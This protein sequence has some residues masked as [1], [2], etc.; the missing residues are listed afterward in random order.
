MKKTEFVCHLYVVVR[1]TENIVTGQ[2]C[3]SNLSVFDN[4]PDAFE[5]ANNLEHFAHEGI[6][7]NCLITFEVEQLFQVKFVD[8]ENK[9]STSN[10]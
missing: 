3:R 7:R 9:N 5:Y 1:V 8:D 4:R 10:E 2:K 6:D